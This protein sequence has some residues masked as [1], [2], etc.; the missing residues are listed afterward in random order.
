MLAKRLGAT[1]EMRLLRPCSNI[2]LFQVA[3]VLGSPS[4]RQ[5]LNDTAYDRLAETN[6]KILRRSPMHVNASFESCYR[7]NGASSKAR[8]AWLSKELVSQK[9]QTLEKLNF[10]PMISKDLVWHELCEHFQAVVTK[11]A[12]ILNRTF[13]SAATGS[14]P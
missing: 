12:A 3:R 14:E 8:R 1:L 7:G 9:M 5:E 2:L 4:D 10:S 6:P 11:S 13:R